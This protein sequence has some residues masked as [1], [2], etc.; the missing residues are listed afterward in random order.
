M[1]SPPPVTD[2]L[3]YISL[4]CGKVS[5][6]LSK[7]RD[8]VEHAGE[9]VEDAAR[10]QPAASSGGSMCGGSKKAAVAVAPASGLVDDILQ[11]EVQR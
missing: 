1:G 4:S 7:L 2:N 11:H 10:P 3:P 9:L 5:G 6:T 8:A